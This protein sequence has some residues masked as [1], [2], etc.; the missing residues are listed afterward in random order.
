MVIE[1]AAGSQPGSLAATALTVKVGLLSALPVIPGALAS[2]GG[3]TGGGGGGTGGGGGGTGGG[4][5]GGGT[6]GPGPASACLNPAIYTSPITAHLEYN[7]TGIATGTSITD[8]TSALNVPFEGQTATEFTSSQST[9]YT[10]IPTTLSTVKGYMRLDDLDVL[11][12]GSTAEVTSPLSGT[13]KLVNSPPK[14]DKR[15]SLGIGESATQTYSVTS[16][17]NFTG[18]GGPITTTQSQTDT[19]KYLGRET[20]TVAAGTF[21]T[22]KF[23]ETSGSGGTTTTWMGSGNAA[24]AFIKSQSVSSNGTLALELKTGSL[25]GSTIRP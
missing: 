15:Y 3:G 23:E 18:L 20:V 11:T 13:I 1:A 6:G 12:F 5:G 8:T 7:A 2:S 21:D 25:N 16:T 24:F 4:G 22:C 9:S 14:R 19:V 17:S 10:G